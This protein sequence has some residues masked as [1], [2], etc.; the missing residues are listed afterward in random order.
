MFPTSYSNG[1]LLFPC[2]SQISGHGKLEDPKNPPNA[3][4]SQ[5]ATLNIDI[6]RCQ[7]CI[8]DCLS[9]LTQGTKFNGRYSIF[10]ILL[11]L[12]LRVFTH[13]V[14]KNDKSISQNVKHC[15][16][17]TALHARHRGGTQGTTKDLGVDDHHIGVAKSKA[18]EI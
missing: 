13:M 16:T 10:E 8:H 11:Q 14:S 5:T 18:L 1:F 6:I 4:L 7:S 12:C 3:T 15:F 2:P 17:P 9:W